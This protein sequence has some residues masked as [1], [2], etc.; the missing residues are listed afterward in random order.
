MLVHTVQTTINPQE[1][2]VNTEGFKMALDSLLGP[3]RCTGDLATDCRAAIVE[4][5]RRRDRNTLDGGAVIAVM[6]SPVEQGGLGWS[7]RQI[8][9]ETTL[10]PRTA[11]RWQEQVV[12]ADP[13][14][15]P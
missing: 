4:A 13:E 10:P 1:L 6:R 12:A 11:G 8:T 3:D 15:S 2:D 7:L 14:R 9:L 5:I